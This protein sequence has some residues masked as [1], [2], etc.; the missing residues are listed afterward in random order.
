MAVAYD[1][2]RTTPEVAYQGPTLDGF[3]TFAPNETKTLFSASDSDGRVGAVWLRIKADA[4]WAPLDR[5][6]FVLQPEHLYN[7][8][9]P[10]LK[11]GLIREFG[12][13]DSAARS[14]YE[15]FGSA[16]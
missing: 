12:Q 16:A 4:E 6:S 7:G 10:S 1:Y 11:G 14:F 2:H 9:Y 3:W 13:T 15:S 8:I 5:T